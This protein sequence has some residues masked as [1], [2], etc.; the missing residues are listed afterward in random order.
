MFRCP[1]F[2]KLRHYFISLSVQGVIWVL[3]CTFFPDG[4]ITAYPQIV[5]GICNF[6]T[7]LAASECAPPPPPQVRGGGHTRLHCRRRVGG[8]P[9]LT[10]GHILYTVVLYIY[11]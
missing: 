11:I 1:Y 7:P 6:S 10:R 4:G 9:I 5:V 3:L 2:L 8:V